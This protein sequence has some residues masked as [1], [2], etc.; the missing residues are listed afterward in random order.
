MN[1]RLEILDV[2]DVQRIK[3]KSGKSV[4]VLGVNEGRM[5]GFEVK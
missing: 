2:R 5:R 4:Y 3:M 1:G